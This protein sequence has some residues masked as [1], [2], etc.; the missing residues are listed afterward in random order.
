[1]IAEA[2][3][4]AAH[5]LGR[6]DGAAVLAR[7][8]G[9]IGRDARAAFASATKL[10]RAQ[11]LATARLA[12][13]VRFRA[14]HVSWIEAALADLPARARSAVANGGDA[15]DLWLARW[16]LAGFV[17]M[18]AATSRVQTPA[19]LP[20]LEPEALRAW[21]ERAGA[22]QLA[23]AAQLAGGDVFAP[24]ERDPVLVAALERIA[25]PPRVHQLGADRAIVKRCAGIAND[26]RRFVRLGARTVAPH[27]D[28]RVCRQLVQRL[29]RALSIGEDLRAFAADPHPA[30][31][32]ALA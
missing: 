9:A 10:R 32:S 22:D 23:R 27:L 16:A 11:W 12:L 29:P 5:K 15:T 21:L 13:P 17:E 24:A 6:D 26:E 30:S 18:P 14:I 28:A 3:A 25:R 20:G 4:A 19:D 2:L 7:I 1:M 31:W 8:G